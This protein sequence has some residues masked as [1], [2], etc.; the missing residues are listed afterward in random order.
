MTTP[1]ST[2]RKAQEVVAAIAAEVTGRPLAVVHVDDA[3]LTAGMVGAG[4]PEP[5][6]ELLTSF[7]KAIRLGHAEVATQVAE[8]TGRAPTSVRD[9]LATNKAVFST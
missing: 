2:L 3:A 7:E 8:L 6:A 5:V 4:L 9:F 1:E